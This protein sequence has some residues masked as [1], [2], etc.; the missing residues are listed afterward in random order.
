MPQ[1]R[2]YAV[3][4][5]GKIGDAQSSTALRHIIEDDYEKEYTRFLL[6]E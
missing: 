6:L 3:K 5:L 1:V 2:Q 4:A